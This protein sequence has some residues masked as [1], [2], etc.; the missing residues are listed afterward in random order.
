MN[1]LK[2]IG[3]IVLLAI[4][5]TQVLSL[6]AQPVS[7]NTVTVTGTVNEIS[8]LTLSTN[9]VALPSGNP[10]ETKTAEP[11]LTL[12][13]KRNT[14]GSWQL[15]TRALSS[16]LSN[17]GS[18]INIANLKWKGGDAADYTSFG[19]AYSTVVQGS[20]PTSGSGQMVDLSLSLA[21]PSTA[22][23][24]TYSVQIEFVLS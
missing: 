12:T 23:P 4:S 8:S 6:S 24:G 16:T 14:S 19:T 18:T 21:Y 1:W 17:G 2:L 7:A 20:G 10:G 9:S 13:I 11:A 3:G 22:T 15:Q 5:L